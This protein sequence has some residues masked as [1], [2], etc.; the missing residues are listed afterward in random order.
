MTDWDR[1][2][3][4]CQ[5]FLDLPES[6]LDSLW[7]ERIAQG[8]LNESRDSPEIVMPLFRRAL[9]KEDPSWYSHFSLA[10][11]HYQLGHLPEAI[12]ETEL[13]LE[14][15]KCE[16][17]RP[18]PSDADLMMIHF[19]LGCLY[20][21][22]EN[23][24]QATE[25]FLI[26]SKGSD[27]Y[28]AEQ[29]RVAYMKAILKANDTEGAK[30][31]L[32]SA[33]VTDESE[34]SKVR[35]LKMIAKDYEHN[36]TISKMFDT[37]KRDPELFEELT[38]VFKKATDPLASGHDQVP[39]MSRDDRFADQEARGVLLYHWGMTVAYR[40]PSEDTKSV[41]N[42]L[43]FWEECRDQLRIIGG[44]VASTTRTNATSQLAK[45]YF[46]SLL[47]G[48]GPTEHFE[49]LSKL[50]DEDSSAEGEDPAGYLAILY[51]LRDEK[52]KA[53]ERLSRRIKI[54]MDILSDDQPQNDYLGHRA[55]F[56]CLA[57]YQ[58][59][60]NAAAALTLMGA[61][62]LVTDAL[63]FEDYDMSGEDDTAS[64]DGAEKDLIIELLKNTGKKISHM[65][66]M[67]V[68]DSSQQTRRIELAKEE[69]EGLV[70][71]DPTT[72]KVNAIL[73]ARI[74]ALQES[75][76]SVMQEAVYTYGWG[77]NGLGPPGTTCDK[78]A[79]FDHEFVH[80]I[81]CAS[82]DFCP[83]CFKKLRQ[84]STPAMQCSAEHVW[85]KVPR[86]GSEFY[87]GTAAK[88]L[89]VPV[90]RPIEGDRNLLEA[91]YDGDQE[92]QELT[93]EAWKAGLA[94]EWDITLEE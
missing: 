56:K 14:S 30:N 61:P 17:C 70:D 10:G 15:T 58:D 63:Q 47:N 22:T 5:T 1:V 55:L 64:E 75:Q 21:G 60:D 34:A 9:A 48:Q 29:G 81:H 90:V 37:A 83:D 33:F 31:M 44:P 2:S 84:Q 69:V 43:T 54:A 8:A 67:K 41:A 71:T 52:D 78:Q 86:Q 62:D 12:A 36:Y 74:S 59:F 53:K 23:I 50:A 79:D 88:S 13:T 57:Y 49:A 82:C 16:G 45:Y 27:T 39:D 25:Q 46:Q 32:R 42:A 93:L 65:V 92:I 28:W 80:C 6:E 87:R 11:C 85:I 76:A 72:S 51:A 40:M 68:P 7:W 4:W 26:V 35:V 77:C 73:K 91:C 66:K 3:A 18:A 89:R 24:Q 19:R 38:A 20:L 94:K